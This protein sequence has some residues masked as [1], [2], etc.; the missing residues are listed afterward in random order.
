MNE[1]AVQALEGILDI[2]ENIYGVAMVDGKG[3]VLAQTSNWDLKKDAPGLVSAWNSNQGSVSI[4]GIRYVVV[5]NTPER[6]IGTNATGKGHVIGVSAGAAK[7]II[8]INPAIGPTQVLNDV[9][10]E[11][12]KIGKML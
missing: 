4:L 12:L 9:F 8:Y 7:I 6:L 5:E 3:K 1:E 2:N 10:M 11:G